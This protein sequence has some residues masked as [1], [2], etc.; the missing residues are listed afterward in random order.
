MYVPLPLYLWGAANRN[1]PSGG[2]AYGIPKY[3]QTSF[4]SS[5]RW[6]VIR[7]FSVSTFSKEDVFGTA[8]DNPAAQSHNDSAARLC[9]LKWRRGA[10]GT[11]LDRNV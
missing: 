4:A 3:S 6:P 1:A 10:E 11:S 7:P 8:R 9:I 5:E 2:C